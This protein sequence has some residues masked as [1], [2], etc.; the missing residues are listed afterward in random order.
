MVSESRGKHL[1]RLQNAGHVVLLIFLCTAMRAQSNGYL[2]EPAAHSTGTF[3]NPLLPSGPDPW[4]T[5]KDGYYYYM[6]ST[7]DNLTL[8]KTRSVVDLKNATKK[9]VWTPPATGPYSHDLWAPE[10]HFLN[11]KWYIYFAADASTN[12]THRLW[13]VEN[14]SPDPLAGEWTFK[15]KVTDA[16]DRWAIDGSV[17]EDQGKLY[18]IWSG[19]DGDTNGIQNIYIARMKNPWTVESA[20]L[21]VSTPEYPWEKVGDVDQKKNPE[22]PPHIDVNEGPEILQHDD[23]IFLIYSASACWTDY[24]ELGMVTAISGSDLL[25]PSSWKKSPRPVFQAAPENGVY[26]TGHNSFF[27]SP[28]GK[29]SWILYHANPESGQGC[30]L[31]RSPRAQPFT[32]KSDGTPDF[33]KPLATNTPLTRPSGDPAN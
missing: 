23:K 4:V 7:G 33:G 25:N 22:D 30:G 32:W 28:D 8:W 14:P 18:L 6:N 2:S 31:H 19:W 10:I 17:F 24:Y 11:G 20:R 9:V 27:Q 3:T 26:A 16:S 21:R 5:Y 13:V 29:Q 12:Q 15:G 1:R